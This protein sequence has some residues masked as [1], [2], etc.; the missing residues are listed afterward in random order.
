MAGNGGQ[1]KKAAI[2]RAGD[3]VY[4]PAPKVLGLVQGA[5]SAFFY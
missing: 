5:F 1:A 4:N 3:S 2:E